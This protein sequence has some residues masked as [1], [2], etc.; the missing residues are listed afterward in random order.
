M[1]DAHEIQREAIAD[2][3]RAAG[4]SAEDVAIAALVMM[5]FTLTLAVLV[6]WIVPLPNLVLQAIWVI[7]TAIA[8]AWN[9][10][11]RARTGI[12]DSGE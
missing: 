6:G 8:A 7:A 1:M 11:W 12:A 5:P 4:L 10:G 9:A 2:A 3:R